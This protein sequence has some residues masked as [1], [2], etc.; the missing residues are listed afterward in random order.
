MGLIGG[1]VA[2]AL[3][4][5]GSAPHIVGVGRTEISLQNALALGVIDSAQTSISDALE[6]ADLILIATPVAQTASILQSI[7]PHLKQQ[8]IITDAGQ[9]QG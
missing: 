4:N 2:L 5:T 9:H 6:D 1:S 7:K 8:T 3:K